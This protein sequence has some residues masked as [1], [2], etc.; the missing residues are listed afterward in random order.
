MNLTV[1]T[2][3]SVS[4]RTK[5]KPE[6]RFWTSISIVSE[7]FDR[8]HTNVPKTV[9]IS[10]LQTGDEALTNNLSRTGFG[11]IVTEDVT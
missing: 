11:K 1:T 2:S 3:F 5:Y 9:K 6:L 4:N 7:P 10:I 8:S